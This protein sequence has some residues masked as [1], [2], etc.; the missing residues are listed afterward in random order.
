MTNWTKHGGLLAA[1]IL[2]AGILTTGSAS[3]RPSGTTGAGNTAAACLLNLG[4]VTAGGDHRMQTITADGARVEDRMVAK[5]LYPDGQVRLSATFRYGAAGTL[6]LGIDNDTG[7]G[8]LYSV[9]H[10][11]GAATVIRSIG[12]VPDSF[13]DP[14]YFHWGRGSP[15][16]AWPASDPAVTSSPHPLPRAGRPA[17]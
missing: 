6:L 15:T 5:D 4:S 10:A 11:N 9:G 17:V 12:K 2:S 14:V 7:S 16:D 3:A 8:Y 1:G 13:T